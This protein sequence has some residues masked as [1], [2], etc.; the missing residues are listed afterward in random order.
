[1]AQVEKIETYDVAIESFYNVIVDYE[2]YPE[3]VDGM[4]S[5][6]ILKNTAKAFEVEYELD[7]IKKFKYTLTHKHKKNKEVS[8]SLKEGDLFKKSEGSWTLKKIDAHTTEVTYKLDVE[9]KLFAP[10]MIVKKLVNVQVPNT[11]EAYYQR[12]KSLYE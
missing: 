10:K 7:L 8:W 11:M 3:F 12:A 6:K 5:V 1:M 2:S 4:S 9:M